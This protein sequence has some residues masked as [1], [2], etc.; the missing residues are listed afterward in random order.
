[1][2]WDHARALRK[3]GMDVQSHTRTHRVL[4]TLTPDE[5]QD[6]LE[7]SRTDLAR[8]LGEPIRAVAYPVGNPL[9]VASSIRPA[10]VKA[11]YEIG[12][13]N[14]TGPTSLREPLDPFGIGRQTV[15]RALSEALFLSMLALPE[16]AAKHPWHLPAN[17]VTAD[18]PV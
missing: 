1:M 12:F 10:L 13:T 11:G 16:L 2:T 17:V 18:T 4:Q 5:V 14:G 15:E 6:E 9:S 7:G 3:A 8:E